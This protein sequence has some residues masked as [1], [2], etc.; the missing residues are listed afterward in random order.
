MTHRSALVQGISEIK[1]ETAGS[2]EDLILKGEILINSEKES[3]IF[4]KG[5]GGF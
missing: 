5:K 1:S 3:R 2:S 4:K